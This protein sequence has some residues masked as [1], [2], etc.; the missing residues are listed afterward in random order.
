VWTS[1]L[2]EIE[3][4]ESHRCRNVDVK[5]AGFRGACHDRPAD[6][7]GVEAEVYL[8]SGVDDHPIDISLVLEQF[9]IATPE[10]AA[11]FAAPP[12]EGSRSRRRWF[13]LSA[14]DRYG[15]RALTGAMRP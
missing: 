5:I 6:S 10:A 11:R 1:Y 14:A 4:D 7:N 13:S 3:I 2:F 9:P 12:K 8:S 15:S